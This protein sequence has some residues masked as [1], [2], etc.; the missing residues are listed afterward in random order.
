MCV[1]VM[2]SVEGC[3][4]SEE[5]RVW[6]SGGTTGHY[7]APLVSCLHLSAASWTLPHLWCRYIVCRYL[8]C[9]YLVVDILVCPYMM[10][11]GVKGGVTELWYLVLTF[12]NDSKIAVI[13]WKVFVYP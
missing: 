3:V 6:V 5:R 13:G 11:C 9:R 2:S 8:P 10:W 4:R 7:R 12:H 1:D